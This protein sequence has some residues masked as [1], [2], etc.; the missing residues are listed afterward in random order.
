[1]D[2]KKN[3]KWHLT[4]SPG[5]PLLKCR[6]TFVLIRARISVFLGKSVAWRTLFLKF[7][8]SHAVFQSFVISADIH[9]T[10]EMFSPSDIR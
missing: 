8:M 5:I 4:G 1:M 2:I 9:I 10:P 6:D 3:R 7:Q